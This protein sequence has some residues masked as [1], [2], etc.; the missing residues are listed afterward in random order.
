MEPTTLQMTWFVLLGLLM[1]GYA[2]LDGFDL[3][4]GILHLFAR[5]DS[6]R[7][8]FM[9]SIG[10]LWDGN[11]VWLVV[12]GGALFAAFPKAYAA[13]FSG[14]YT[15]F[16]LLVCCLIFRGVSMEFRSKRESRW[17]RQAWDIAFCVASA[18]VSFLFGVVV[19]NCVQGLP[20]GADGDLTRPLGIADV[21]LGAGEASLRGYPI[22]T[23]LFAV[24][25]FAMHGS[26]Y[27]HLKTE[28]DL[29]A[30]IRRWMWLTYFAF[31]ALYLL[32][33][34]CTLVALPTATAN[35]GQYPV[36]WVVPILNVLAILNIP[37]AIHQD[38]PF[39]AF[40]S[41]AC[42]IAAATFL[43]GVALFPHL[44]VATENPAYGLTVSN[45]ASTEKTLGIMLLMAALGLPF[46]LAYTATIYWVFRG[47]VQIGKF[48]Y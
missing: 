38:R 39:D 15:A 5:N 16:M 32:L 43:F 44:L 8:I 26:I 3:G 4:V 13:A 23:G 22:V 31:L 25:I 36:L 34:A 46:V 30:R 28:G 12:F 47:K 10:P 27:L 33:S 20:L 45:A 11:E 19:G 48:S 40:L 17:W 42:V 41:S 18:L 37:R 24:G 14:M 21:L 2:I 35:F 1:A 9:N 29:Q 7:R 6:E